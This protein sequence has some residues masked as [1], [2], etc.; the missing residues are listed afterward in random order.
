MRQNGGAA[1]VAFEKARA[2]INPQ[3]GCA[4]KYKTGGKCTQF[5]LLSLENLRV[6]IT[7]K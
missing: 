1:P 7:I 5:T 2:P 6:I 4:Y 3:A